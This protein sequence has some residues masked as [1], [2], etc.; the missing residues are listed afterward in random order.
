MTNKKLIA[1]FMMLA[2]FALFISGCAND[3][4]TTISTTS[5]GTATETE[6]IQEV[7]S[8]LVPEENSEVAIGDLI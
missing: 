6:V 4:A 5:S 2:V 1:L 3:G 8:N 7:D